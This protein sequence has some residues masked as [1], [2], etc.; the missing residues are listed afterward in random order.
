[1]ATHLPA[2]WPRVRTLKNKPVARHRHRRSVG[3]FYFIFQSTR[4]RTKQM[5]QHRTLKNKTPNVSPRQGFRSVCSLMLSPSVLSFPLSGGGCLVEPRFSVARQQF[6][7]VWFAS[8]YLGFFFV[9]LTAVSIR[10]EV[11]RIAMNK[12]E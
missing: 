7:A 11:S 6:R 5:T 3:V 2:V 1:M 4:W 12:S 9:L 10:G 8:A